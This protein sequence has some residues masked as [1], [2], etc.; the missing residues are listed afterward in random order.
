MYASSSAVVDLMGEQTSVHDNEGDGLYACYRASAYQD[1]AAINV[2]QPCILNDMSHGNKRQ[3][4]RELSG[5]LVQQKDSKPYGFQCRF[6]VPKAQVVD[7]HNELQR[8][9]GETEIEAVQN[10]LNVAV[11]KLSK[12]K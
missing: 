1:G 7:V 3:N 10:L 5:G 4:I 11:G 6:E 9:I 2:Y 8:L 12:I